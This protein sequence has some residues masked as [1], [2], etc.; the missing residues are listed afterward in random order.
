MEKTLLGFI[1]DIIHRCYVLE[2][3]AVKLFTANREKERER[4]REREREPE[5]RER[6]RERDGSSLTKVLFP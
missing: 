2:V 5:Q 4:E 1:G 6:E 3:L